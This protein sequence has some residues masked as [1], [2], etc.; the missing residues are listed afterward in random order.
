MDAWLGIVRHNQLKG[1][2]APL[3]IARGVLSTAFAAGMV[4]GI[5]AGLVIGLCLGFFSKSDYGHHD[6]F[7][8]ILTFNVPRFADQMS[9]I[10]P[11]N[12]AE[13]ARGAL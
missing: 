9:P 10:L 4:L 6:D 8:L 12:K 3:P 2:A 7:S 5:I 13:P 1:H 11:L